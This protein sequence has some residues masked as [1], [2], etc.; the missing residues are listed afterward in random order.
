MTNNKNTQHEIYIPA[1]SR[2]LIDIE[3]YIEKINR[4][5]LRV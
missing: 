1:F 3:V 5:R 2:P 4:T